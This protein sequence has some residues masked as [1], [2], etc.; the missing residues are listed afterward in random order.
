MTYHKEYTST[1]GFND[2]STLSSIERPVIYIH[3][4]KGQELM[5]PDAQ[6]LHSGLKYLFKNAIILKKPVW[7]KR[8]NCASTNH[9]G[10]GTIISFKKVPK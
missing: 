3:L 7:F 2:G 4:A 9:H 10:G 1:Y 5:L 6:K 8:N